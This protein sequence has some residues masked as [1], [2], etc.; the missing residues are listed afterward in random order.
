MLVFLLVCTETWVDVG[1]YIYMFKYKKRTRSKKIEVLFSC[2]HKHGEGYLESQGVG[3][4]SCH[5]ADAPAVRWRGI[6]HC[7]H[8]GGE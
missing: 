1:I 7:S 6:S 5:A 4:G 3:C 2:R 8:G